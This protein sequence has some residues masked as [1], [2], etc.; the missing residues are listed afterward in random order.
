M[1]LRD[2]LIEFR[3]DFVQGDNR[4]IT[5]AWLAS[6]VT[7]VGMGWFLASRSDS[8]QGIAES[9][10]YQIT[11]ERPVSV[12]QFFVNPGQV[13]ARVRRSSSWIRANSRHESEMC[14]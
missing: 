12:R 10:E 7:V 2:H 6:I 3:Q 4:L 1:T 9:R 14:E 11:F 13:V 5:W 8:F